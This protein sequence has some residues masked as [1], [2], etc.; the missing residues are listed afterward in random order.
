[1]T[2]TKAKIRGFLAGFFRGHELTDDEDLFAT[3]YVNSM[4][5]MQLVQFVEQEFGVEVENE[6][7]DIDNFRS[8]DAIAAL[9]EKKRAAAAA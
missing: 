8:V 6:D 7:L 9:V 4:F 1:M 2:E 3:G 5:A